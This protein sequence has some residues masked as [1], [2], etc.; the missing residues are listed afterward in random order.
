M[1]SRPGAGAS[2]AAAGLA[3]VVVGG[4]WWSA[5]AMER[6]VQDRS[7]QALD[8]AG[9]HEVRV[10]ADGRDLIVS[11]VDDAGR[12]EAVRSTLSDVAGAGRVRG[13]ALGA[14]VS[15]APA[16]SGVAPS[17]EPTPAGSAPDASPSVTSPAPS[18]TT[19]S[20]DRDAAGLP[21]APAP[22]S[23]IRFASGSSDLDAEARAAAVRIAAYLERYEGLSVVL[24]GRT[25]G[26][27]STDASLSLSWQRAQQVG[28]A[29]V[30]AGI[31]PS[32]VSTAGTGEMVVDN[33][34]MASLLRRVD[35][36]YEE[37]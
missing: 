7:R 14:P 34:S 3:L 9:L 37:R 30:A 6:D 23:A 35:V 16:T 28:D 4:A 24:I 27:G 15:A 32:R 20:R 26:E 5:S 25:S 2:L 13:E 22:T 1:G 36:V 18:S 19:P 31:A 11:G 29:V 33:P 12:I 21:P 8:S 17:E 10:T